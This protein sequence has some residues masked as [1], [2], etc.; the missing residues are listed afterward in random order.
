MKHWTQI[1]SVTDLKQFQIDFRELSDEEQSE[2]TTEMVVQLNL[3]KMKQSQTDLFRP[4]QVEEEPLLRA[5]RPRGARK[6]PR[7]ARRPLFD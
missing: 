4:R 2:I 1:R 3:F 7:G 5:K 6:L